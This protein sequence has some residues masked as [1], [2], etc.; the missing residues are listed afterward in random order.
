MLGLIHIVNYV[1]P[2]INEA[3][4]NLKALQLLLDLENK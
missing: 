3:D 1:K 2:T 4:K